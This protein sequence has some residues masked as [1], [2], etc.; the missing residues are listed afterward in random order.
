MTKLGAKKTPPRKTTDARWVD[1]GKYWDGDAGAALGEQSTGGAGSARDDVHPWEA[2]AAQED[3]LVNRLMAD[4][5]MSRE[6]ALAAVDQ[7]FGTGMGNLRGAKDKA[8]FYQQQELYKLG[9]FL[10]SDE[11]GAIDPAEY[12]GDLDSEGAKARADQ[13]SRDAQYDAL[14]KLE[15]WTKPE[16]TAEE[17]FMMEV[18]RSNQERDMRSS[19]EAA[20]RDMSARGVR[21][22]A[23]EMA[24]TLGGAQQTSQNRLLSDLGAQANAQKRA[25]GATEAYGQQARDISGQTFDEGFKTGTAADE[26]NKFNNK[27]RS[28]YGAEKQRFKLEQQEKRSGRQFD[29]TDRTTKAQGD[30]FDREKGIADYGAKGAAFKTAALTGGQVSDALKIAL[31]QTEAEKAAKALKDQEDDSFNLFKPNTWL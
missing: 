15:G 30:S 12:V 23:A 29:L 7:I 8:D 9:G 14:G 24:A 18:A 2:D 16:I 20:L 1:K 17:R 31:G 28:D 11:M 5:K 22:G 21:S 4:A 27:L 26:I 25:L 13:R 6:Q 19:R 3:D 10:N